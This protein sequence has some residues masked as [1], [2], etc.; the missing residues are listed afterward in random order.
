MKLVWTL[1]H[2]GYLKLLFLIAFQVLPTVIKDV[3]WDSVSILR[4]VKKVRCK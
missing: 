4:T 1:W 3:F 2:S